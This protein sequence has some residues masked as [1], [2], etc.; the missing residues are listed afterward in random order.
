MEIPEDL[1]CLYTARIEDR[2]GSH[3]V[4]VPDRELTHGDVE[5]GEFYRVALIPTETEA[6]SAEEAPARESRRETGREHRDPPVDEGE[7]R[8]YQCRPLGGPPEDVETLLDNKSV[9]AE[10]RITPEGWAQRRRFADRQEFDAFRSFCRENDVDFRLD[11]LV[12][13]DGEGAAEG[14]V[15]DPGPEPLDGMTAAQREALVTAHEMGYFDV[16]RAATLAEV[17]AELDV[18]A[19]SL[20]ER[21]RRAQS[22]LVGQFRQTGI[23]PRTN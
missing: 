16:P 3:V 10:V 22:H 9:A 2:R 1:L 21:L 7:R 15:G 13:T 4:E 12:E 18:A 23:K 11:R 14:S 5:E 20:S 6:E 19:A 17:A 8:Q